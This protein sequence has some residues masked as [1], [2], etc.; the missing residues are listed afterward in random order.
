[1]KSETSVFT[2]DNYQDYAE[3]KAKK[4]PLLRDFVLSF[5]IGGSICLI[6]QAIKTI[7]F[8]MK[9]EEDQIK[10]IVPILL[11]F[12]SCALTG[13]GWYDSLAKIGGAG[14][15]VP[16]TGFANA[17][18]SPTIDNKAEGYVL[19]VGA[20]MFIIAGPVIVYGV[21]TSIL[22]GIIYWIT[23]LF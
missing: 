6:G 13:A 12:I 14:T 22:Y 11:I 21:S 4:S 9:I 5:L 19:G 20:K 2:K 23:T 17:M 18:C 10:I 1:M 3:R 8:L 7:G 16:I 15:L